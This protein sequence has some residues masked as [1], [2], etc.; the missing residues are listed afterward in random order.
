MPFS[1]LPSAGMDPD[2]PLYPFWGSDLHENERRPGP[3]RRTD[4]HDVR[5]GYRVYGAGAVMTE[6]GWKMVQPPPGRDGVF[7]SIWGEKLSTP[8]QAVRDAAY[9]A[10]TDP[11]GLNVPPMP[12]QPA[13]AAGGVVE[14]D[15]SFHAPTGIMRIRSRWFRRACIPPLL[16]FTVAVYVLLGLFWVLSTMIEVVA[17]MIRGAALE[18]G[19]V[20]RVAW[21]WAR[22][23][24]DD[25]VGSLIRGARNAWRGQ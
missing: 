18:A 16:L 9:A 8:A 22:S 3:V 21:R 2:E 15:P 6:D 25:G 17:A 24:A 20:C 7:T 13:A 11:D 1:H 14:G 19:S 5:P 23:I 12:R 4:D 10:A